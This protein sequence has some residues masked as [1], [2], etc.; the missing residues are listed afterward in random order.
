VVTGGCGFIGQH[1]TRAL[2]GL[3]QEV[4]V[5][6]K[7]TADEAPDLPGASLVHADVRDRDQVEQALQGAELVFHVAANASGTLSI[8]DPRWDYETNSMG[9]FNVVQAALAV[10]ARRLVY[11]SS[12]S[13]YGRPQRF[14]MDEAHPLR[15]FVPYGASKL[16]G[17]LTCLSFQST[18]GLPCVIGRPFCVYGPG[19]LPETALVEVA[20]YLRWH[21]RGEAIQVVGD[22]ERKTRDFVHV[23]DLVAGLLVIADRAEPGE[24]FN[25]G[26][27]QESSM[28]QLVDV[29]GKATER[30]PL[31]TEIPE[32]ADDTYRLVADISKLE[33]LGY[34]PAM[35]LEDGVADLA[36]RLGANPEAPGA[37][38]IFRPGQQAE[39]VLRSQPVVA[40]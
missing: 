39:L 40:D 5:A 21:L 11:L 27:G 37:A 13:A 14:P 22:A 30:T 32:I 18:Y 33:A 38:T 7:L 34:R 10:G 28:R 20:R 19:E 9:T 31:V 24:I 29:I 17:E 26:S 12:A 36:R 25:V 16:A 3:G 2:V 8:A 1:L 6:D 4:V 15:P 35:S 23:S